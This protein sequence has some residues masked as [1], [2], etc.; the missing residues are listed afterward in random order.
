MGTDMRLTPKNW[1]DFQHYKKRRPPWI[2]LY[3]ILLDDYDFHQ[4]PV[5]S[6][7]LAPMLWLLASEF[8]GGCIDLD[9]KA[10]AFR[11]HLDSRALASALKPLIDNGFFDVASDVLAPRKQ[12]A[13]PETEGETETET[14]GDC[15]PDDAPPKQ[16]RIT[17]PMDL[18]ATDYQANGIN[19]SLE[20]DKFRDWSKAHG[21]RHK[22][23]AAAFRNWLRN[24]GKF[25]GLDG[26]NGADPPATRTRAERLAF[27][28]D[29]ERKMAERNG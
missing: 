26:G 11:L 28:A 21:K 15:A 20:L 6:R 19:V 5:A 8:D 4:L 25:N 16:T 17:N 14:E 24:S 7:A 9:S 27:K 1:T 29:Y 10:L 18:K 23:A 22:D 3:R 12:H 2:R 13:T